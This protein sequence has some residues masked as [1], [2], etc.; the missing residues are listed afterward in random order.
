[1]ASMQSILETERFSIYYNTETRVLRL[2]WDG[3]FRSEEYRKHLDYALEVF[4]KYRLKKWVNNMK[5]MSVISLQD[6]EW[7]NN[8]WLGRVLEAGILQMVNV[9]SDDVF[10]QV[11]MRN[12]QNY[13][14][15]CGLRWQ[16]IDKLEKEYC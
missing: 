3:F 7:T 14:N 1:M 5:N 12:I 8:D 16:N 13:A 10:H 9:T 6:Q 4:K 2:D 11:S 15:L